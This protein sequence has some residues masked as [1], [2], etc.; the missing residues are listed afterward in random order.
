MWPLEYYSAVEETPSRKTN[1]RQGRQPSQSARITLNG[2]RP[3]FLFLFL[4]RIIFATTPP[5]DGQA[6]RCGRTLR[7]STFQYHNFPKARSSFLCVSVFLFSID[8]FVLT[9]P[10]FLFDTRRSTCALFSWLPNIYLRKTR[11]HGRT[12]DRMH[13]R[14]GSALT[15]A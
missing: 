12:P 13:A 11:M 9:P 7:G 5:Q 3:L 14:T 6:S 1:P 2:T 15:A 8:C 4:C 10:R